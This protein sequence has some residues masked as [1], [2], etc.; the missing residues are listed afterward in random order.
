MGTG[1]CFT[2][3]LTTDSNSVTL[4]FINNMAPSP[5]SPSAKP[6]GSPHMAPRYDCK[7]AY[8][9]VAAKQMKRWIQDMQR[10]SRTVRL[11]PEMR[12]ACAYF[13]VPMGRD[14]N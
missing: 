5:K 12:S 11:S 13:T 8:G 9:H 3:G 6:K 10:V 7:P 1:D 4:L 14:N 2:L